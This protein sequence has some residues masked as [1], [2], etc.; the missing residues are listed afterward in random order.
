MSASS[1]PAPFSCDA[2]PS[3]LLRLGFGAKGSRSSRTVGS[4]RSAAIATPESRDYSHAGGFHG[5]RWLRISS[6][7]SAKSAAHRLGGMKDRHRP[8]AIFNDDFRARSHA[9]HQRSE[10]ARRFRL[11]DVGHILSHEVTPFYAW[12]FFRILL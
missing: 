1:V 4:W 8:L 11:R 12:G 2:Q 7:S 10:V 9:C 5:L 6:T 3:L